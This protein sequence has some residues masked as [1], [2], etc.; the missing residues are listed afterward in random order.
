MGR[1]GKTDKADILKEAE[2]AS[3]GG[4]AVHRA[5]GTARTS[6]GGKREAGRTAA[7]ASATKPA[8]GKVANRR[9]ATKRVPAKLAAEPSAAKAAE[10]PVTRKPAGRFAAKPARR[11]PAP[12]KPDVRGSATGPDAP[13]SPGWL[14]VVGATQN[15]LK[16]VTVGFPLGRFVCVTGVSGSGKSSLVNDVLCETLLRD[17]NGATGTTPGACRRI[18]GTEHLDK[19]IA[20]DQTPIG[21]TP[22]SNPATYIKLFDLIR[23]LY[24]ALPD[25]KVR[26]Y[27]KSRFSFNVASGERGGGRCEACEGNGSNRLDMDFLADVWVT[28]PVCEGKR[29]SRETL[30]VLYKGRSIADVLDMDVQQA[31]EHF[32]HQPKIAAMLQTFHDVGLDYVKLGQPSPTLSGGEAQRI[33]L[34]RELVKV[35]TGR[36]LYIL[37]EPTTGLH[38]ED[39]RKLLEVLHRLVDAGNT[40]VVVEHNLDVVKTADWV[41]DLGP[42][43]GEDGGRVVAEGTPEE[44]AKT[45]GSHTGEALRGALN[46]ELRRTNHDV[47][48]ETGSS[49]VSGGRRRKRAAA[50]KIASD[51]DTSPAMRGSQYGDAIRVRGASEHNLK[52]VNVDVPHRAMTVCCGPSGSGKTSFAIDTL[53]VEGQRRYI[54]SLSAYARQFLGQMQKPRVEHID[55]LA[56]AI[57]IEQKSAGRSPRS[58]VGTV[59]EIYDYLRVLWARLAEGY[60][61]NCDVPVGTQTSDQ[62]VER[63]L[64]LGDGAAVTLLSRIQ[65]EGPETYAQLL[66]RERKQGYARVRLDGRIVSLDAAPDVDARAAHRVE[67]VIDRLTIRAAQRTRLAE[68]VEHALSR[69]EGVMLVTSA[70]SPPD[71]SISPGSDEESGRRPRELRFSQ[72]R[73]C[74]ECGESFEELT[75]HHFSFNSRLGWCE[76]C[77][78]L[79]VQKGANPSAIITN[80]R[81]SILDGA[82]AGWGRIPRGSMLHRL[83]CAVA[84]TIGFDPAV[85]WADLEEGHR[86]TF[87]HGAGD[88]WIDVDGG[89]RIRWRGFYPAIHRATLSNWVYRQRL[90]EMAVDV[91]CEAC[92]GSRLRPDARAARFRGRRLS[93][94]C[95]MP[96]SEALA[97]FEGL[98]LDAREKRVAGDLVDEVRSRLRFLVDVGLDYVSL[99]RSA[100]TLS[101]GESQRIRLASQLGTGLTGVLY[102][103]DEPTIGLHPRDNARLIRALHKLRDLGNT[104]LVVEHDREVIDAADRVLDFG[105]GAGA[106]GGRIVADAPPKRLRDLEDSLTGRYL[107]NT[108]SIPAPTN[109]RPVRAD[110]ADAKDLKW[111]RVHGARENNLKGIDVAFPLGR[112]TCVTGVSGSGKSTLVTDIVYH[113]LASRLHGE[114]VG[115]GAHDRIEGLDRVAKAVNVDQSPI[116]VTPTSTPATYTGVFDIIR[117]LFA[118]LPDAKVRGYTPGRFSFN[119]SGGRCETCEGMGQ[120]RIEMHFL[121]DVWVECDN[122]RGTRYQS[123]TLE[124]RFRGRNIAD[125]LTMTV[126]QAIELFESVPKV[127]RTLQMLDDVGLSYLPLGQSAA[128]LSGGEAQRI[129]LATELARPSTG[130]TVYVLDEPTTGLHFDD[131]QKLLNVL[132]RLVD[133]GNTILC[134]EHN[135]DVIKTCDWVI[136]LGPEAGEG[137]GRIVVEGPPETVAACEASHT[138]RALRPVLDAGP[139]APRPVWDEAKQKLAESE[140]RKAVRV[141][142]TAHAPWQTDGRKWHLKDRIAASQKKVHWDPSVIEWIVGAIEE[143]EGFAPS[144]WNDR[145]RIEIRSPRKEVTWFCHLLTGG[146]DL[147]DVNLRVPDGTFR[148]VELNR[149]L[150][151]KTLDERTDL[152]IYGR[153]PRV[154]IRKAQAGW[155]HV[156]ILPCDMRDIDKRTWKTFLREA[157]TA[158]LSAAGAAVGGASAS[159]QNG[160]GVPARAAR[161]DEPADPR[162]RHLRQ[163]G[164]SRNTPAKWKPDTL[165]WLIGQF[166]KLD[167]ALNVD[168]RKRGAVVLRRESARVPAVRIV[169]NSARALVVELSAPNGALTPTQVENLGRMPKILA[170]GETSLLKFNVCL[171][172][173]VPVRRLGAVWQAATGTG[174]SRSGDR[175]RVEYQ[176]EDGSA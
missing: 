159:D 79:G 18:D 16:G 7:G 104:L 82:V 88:A 75:P 153:W 70:S 89:L 46:V 93:E 155:E 36:T 161:H 111:L 35:A 6:D 144:D 2:P 41:I 26:G 42:E 157:A 103:L 131:I 10:A 94:V 166:Q 115:V 19:V 31:L 114:R 58:T 163:L 49:P 87:L 95:A 149:R 48:A 171:P 119:A 152:P 17:L 145:A 61:P 78:G 136:D 81:R 110:G 72:H 80:P 21:R 52:H 91:P 32:A 85:A 154:N 25:A 98:R 67:L 54:E 128:T 118:R 101:G 116:G 112:F 30:H 107:A 63:I 76:N 147:V 3:R 102:V 59:T 68:S 37:D 24:A 175:S 146:Q 172:E 14:T 121:P 13:P 71:E 125:V 4:G 27:T 150:G 165:L 106:L 29:F 64:A 92:A 170:K 113:A 167:R 44:V 148:E 96:M 55:G 162:Q 141:Q 134:I 142:E 124:V 140:L 83:V 28:C 108:C 129:K 109:R 73:A 132:H 11:K 97:W 127:R 8:A 5:G 15:N 56:P 173:D 164:L 137:G 130:Q 39:V 151:L 126:A 9:A 123:Q 143:V 22:R 90:G 53:Y 174:E 47:P 69:G 99:D 168:W 57:C 139:R 77:E 51:V 65:P 12:G 45:E 133:L 34:A 176:E 156:R 158:Y 86:R 50:G 62:I 33:K 105:P 66:E 38:F 120:R 169:T 43:G 40:V 23:D 1:R 74:E 122:C 100:P 160:G 117:E 135:L 84:E 138:G 60:C 20:I